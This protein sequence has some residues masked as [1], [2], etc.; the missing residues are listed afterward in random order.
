MKTKIDTRIELI[1]RYIDRIENVKILEPLET[2]EAL[3][4]GK[5][6]LVSLENQ[7]EFEIMIWPGYP[8]QFQEME[9]IRFINPKYI[10][11]DHVNGDGSVCLHTNH[12]L[13][14]E[15]KIRQDFDALF[16][17]V[18][19]Y[20]LNQESDKHYEHIIVPEK[21]LHGQRWA[22]LFTNIDHTFKDKEYGFF[23]YSR[24]SDGKYYEDQ[25]ST[26]LVQS[27]WVGKQSIFNQWS[28]AYKSLPK[29]R[30]VFIFTGDPPVKNRRFAID[31]WS[32][33]KPFVSQD[34]FNFLY[35]NERSLIRQE[36][37]G[38]FIP[39]LIG[40]R[41][42]AEETHWQVA[43][44]PIDG[45][46]IKHQKEAGKFFGFF[47]DHP[48][49]WTLTRNCSYEYFFGRGKLSAK[50]TESRILIIGVGA[51]GSMVATTLTRGGCRQ[52]TLIDHDM[53]EAENVC[54]SEYKFI[55]GLSGKVVDL[56]KELL[57]IS[58]FVEVKISEGLTTFIKIKAWDQ[59][60][61]DEVADHLDRFDI[62]FDCS[63]DND[64]AYIL[65][66][67][68]FDGEIFN[69]SI[70]NYA[71]ELVCVGKANLYNWLMTIFNQLINDDS[72]LYNPT[73][74]WSPTFKAS[75]NDIAVLVQYAIKQI[76]RCFEEQT[77]FRNFYLSTS[78]NEG[79]QIKL[80]QY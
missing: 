72:D 40:Y 15:T 17:W 29:Y 68:G 18:Q 66:Q 28:S 31:S 43:L 37:G 35:Q 61:M 22:F 24:L 9:A 69:I 49:D 55:S 58:P 30:G 53:K 64:M 44:M 12:S 5:I 41:I 77:Q 46:P 32:L 56:Q 47:D 34:F 59:Q 36:G 67:I 25:I 79:F 73:G 4:K 60:C 14:L 23:D 26:F 50:F 80:H 74:C 38:P 45:F 51:I 2:K 7:L 16:Q 20:Y 27:F 57:G 62:I 8:L 75:F 1:T 76:N 78:S 48:I 70:T 65:D 11:Y 10:Q 3:I 54:R 6:V 39:L 63:T 42:N 71:R 33:L 19:K 52:L 21:S 13:S